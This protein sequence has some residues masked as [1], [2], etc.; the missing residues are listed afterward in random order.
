M[1]MTPLALALLAGGCSSPEF[2]FADTVD[3]YKMHDQRPDPDLDPV[4]REGRVMVQVTIHRVP[5]AAVED[6]A[7]LEMFEDA[8]ARVTGREAFERNGLRVFVTRPGERAALAERLEAR[9]A[10]SVQRSGFVSPGLSLTVETGPAERRSLRLR[11]PADGGA[12]QEQVEFDTSVVELFPLATAVGGVQVRLVPHLRRVGDAIALWTLPELSAETLLDR[13]RR[14]IV[15][16]IAEPADRFGP[17]F[18][19]SGGGQWIVLEIAC[20]AG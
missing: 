6:L 8:N 14:M 13:E 20:R 4:Q 10:R 2:G 16:P 7:R 3:P 12:V 15:V 11:Q 1:R 17:A 9:G 19:G 18:L 5:A